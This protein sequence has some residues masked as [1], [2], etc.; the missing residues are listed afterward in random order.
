[1]GRGGSTSHS[2]PQ[3]RASCRN[4]LPRQRRG[5]QSSCHHKPR[6]QTLDLAQGWP[7]DGLDANSAAAQEAWEEAGV[8]PANI[9]PDPIGTYDYEKRM[10]E[11]GTV[12]CE[13][14]VYAIEV[15]HLEDEF[16]EASER[17]RKWVSPAE[18]ADLVDEP[19]LQDI[20]RSF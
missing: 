4:L 1:M 16:P 8:K 20:L 5:P 13:T 11:G 19:G 17:T 9:N 2:T 7:I 14:Q 3:P 15:D 12:S 18:A 6:N 10:D